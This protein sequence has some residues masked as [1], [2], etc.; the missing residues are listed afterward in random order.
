MKKN[1][2]VT[3]DLSSMTIYGERSTL[4]KEQSL[5]V[6]EMVENSAE[7]QTKSQFEI[8]YG[9]LLLHERADLKIF[10]Y[11]N[12]Y[13]YGKKVLGMGRGTVSEAIKIAKR[14][15]ASE[16][17]YHISEKYAKYS[18]SVLLALAKSGLTDDEI[19]RLQLK[20][21]AKYFDV[22][23][24]IEKIRYIQTDMPADSS[25]SE[26]NKSESNITDSSIEPEIKSE[27]EIL[28]YKISELP[29]YVREAIQK[30]IR[31]QKKDPIGNYE[32]RIVLNE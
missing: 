1:E 8:A 5:Q 27:I 24:E 7:E 30:Y 14:F 17:V 2:I 23:E 29:L 4:S 26:Q 19:D 32:I 21:N 15:R 18:K 13:D 22:V 31:G 25:E 10:N 12:I 28:E 3:F 11:A 20:D 9:L 6:M 16:H